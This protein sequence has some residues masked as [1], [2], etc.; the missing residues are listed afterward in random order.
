MLFGWADYRASQNDPV[1]R[2][3]GIYR[4]NGGRSATDA[5]A[6]RGMET[7]VKNM[8]TEVRGFIG[9]WCQ[10]AAATPPWQMYGAQHYLTGRSAAFLTANY[11]AVGLSEPGLV[12]ASVNSILSKRPVVIG[13]G[14]MTHYPLMWGWMVRTKQEWY[15]RVSE[16][17]FKVNQG[18][19]EASDW[20]APGTWF[21]G[22]LLPV[23]NQP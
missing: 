10:P 11:N 23:P 21:C 14:W 8:I 6:P 5:V 7:G 18:W 2:N 20:V 12:N 16:Q 15:G 13:T 17:Y 3:W 9:T 4:L 1:W 22:Q 19:G